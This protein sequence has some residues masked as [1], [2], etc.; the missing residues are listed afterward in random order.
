MPNAASIRASANHTL[1]DN[2]Y[3]STKARRTRNPADF[4]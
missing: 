2:E 1:N 4:A 3:Q